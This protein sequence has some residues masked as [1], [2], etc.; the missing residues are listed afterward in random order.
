MNN[1][2]L[3]G[4]YN[5]FTPAPGR[6]GLNEPT[7]GGTRFSPAPG[8]G[9]LNEPTSGG[10]RFTPAPG[11]G[12][13]EEPTSGGSRYTPATFG[14]IGMNDPNVESQLFARR[15]IPPNRRPQPRRTEGTGVR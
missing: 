13:L 6:G 8:R 14:L 15:Y 11:R 4:I 5:L 1:A 7:S 9:G 2:R 3:A 10:S 12:G